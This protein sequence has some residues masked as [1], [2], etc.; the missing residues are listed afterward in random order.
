LIWAVRAVLW[1]RRWR[2]G[3]RVSGVGPAQ[4]A[5]EAAKHHATGNDFDISYDVGVGEQ[6]PYPDAMFDIVVCVDV[7]EHVKNLIQVLVEVVRDLK[8]GALFL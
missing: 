3:A 5:I 7:L 6:M 4:N 1:P 2:K 8:P